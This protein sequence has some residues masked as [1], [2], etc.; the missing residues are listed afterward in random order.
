MP[1]KNNNVRCFNNRDFWN[2]SLI[3]QKKKN[4]TNPFILDYPAN[5][6]TIKLEEAMAD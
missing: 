3:E 6:Q 1:P 5:Y 2:I 4:K